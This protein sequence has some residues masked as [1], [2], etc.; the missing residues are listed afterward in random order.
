MRKKDIKLPEPDTGPSS[1]WHIAEY[2]PIRKFPSYATAEDVR[3]Q[4]V[5][6]YKRG[7]NGQVRVKDDGM[8]RNREEAIKRHPAIKDYQRTALYFFPINPKSGRGYMILRVGGYQC[9]PSFARCQWIKKDGT[10]CLRARFDAHFCC[11]HGG[12][13]P[14][15]LERQQKEKFERM[16]EIQTQ[17]YTP[18]GEFAGLIAKHVDDPK[19]G[20]LSSEIA[21]LR[22]TLDCVIMDKTPQEMASKENVFKLKVLTDAIT[23]AVAA[24]SAIETQ[25]AYAATPQAFAKFV[26]DAGSFVI[27]EYASLVSDLDENDPNLVTLLENISLSYHRWIGWV[28]SYGGRMSL[29]NPALARLSAPRDVIDVSFV[30]EDEMALV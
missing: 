26:Q 10:Q 3:E 1:R 8:P 7:L 20:Q 9:G 16:Q 5:A 30:N 29:G 4:K 13:M 23:K 17:S 25:T 2:K 6:A 27:S 18:S 11:G 15:Y 28:E 24:K 22:A 14:H 12:R 19:L 21:V